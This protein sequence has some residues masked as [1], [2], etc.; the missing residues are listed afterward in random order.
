IDVYSR[1]TGEPYFRIKPEFR[2]PRIRHDPA[3]LRDDDAD[4]A[5]S[6]RWLRRALALSGKSRD[7]SS[8][9]LLQHRRSRRSQIL[10][11]IER[12]E[13]AVELFR[14]AIAEGHPELRKELSRLLMDK[15]DR[16]GIMSDHSGQIEALTRAIGILR[17]L[18]DKSGDPDLLSALGDGYLRLGRA[19]DCLRQLEDAIDHFDQSISIMESIDPAHR[20]SDHLKILARAWISKGT[21]L[22]HLGDYAQARRTIENGLDIINSHRDH[23]DVETLNDMLTVGTMNLA[24][25]V[26]SLDD[27]ST[28]IDLYTRVVKLIRSIDGHETQVNSLYRM[29]MAKSNIGLCYFRSGDIEAALRYLVNSL[30]LLKKLVFDMDQDQFSS[31]YILVCS[32]LGS[33]HEQS[34]NLEKALTIFN[35]AIRF[36]EDIVFNDGR[37]ELLDQLALL[38]RNKA[39]VLVKRGNRII[40]YDLYDNALRI[41]NYLYIRNEGVQVLENATEAREWKADALLL[42][43]RFEDALEELRQASHN[44]EIMIFTFDRSD[45][46]A[47]YNRVLLKRACLM[48]RLGNETAA[49]EYLFIYQNKIQFCPDGQRL[50]VQSP[51][52]EQ[53]IALL[54]KHG[55]SADILHPVRDR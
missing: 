29:A 41:W 54:E 46:K 42:D 12:Y 33:I 32:N 16:H 49:R 6:L 7:A 40:A 19:R 5:A 30:K 17:N 20:T 47:F 11:G 15:S 24:S 22:L 14:S 48:D 26:W 38:Y 1:E 10:S 51:W 23:I 55:F 45:L 34:G 27:I 9:P 50:P 25:A 13:F 2:I 52:K 37:N 4:D 53:C 3:T 21:A 8:T 43:H 35:E 39:S 28:A 31:D 36:H 18:A 44:L